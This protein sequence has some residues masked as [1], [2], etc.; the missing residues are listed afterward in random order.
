MRK[1]CLTIMVLFLVFSGIVFSAST[2]SATIIT[3][4]LGYEFSGA[5]EP[6]GS[7]LPWLVA[8]FDDNNTTGSVTLT[9]SAPG[10]VEV[11]Q[12]K[13]WYFN[14]DTSLLTSPL[15]YSHSSGP[16]AS[17]VDIS[18]NAYRA[19]GVGGD[20]DILFGFGGKSFLATSTATSP[21]TANT[22]SVYEFTATGLIA[23]NFNLSS[24]DPTDT[25]LSY[26][27]AAHIQSIDSITDGEDEGSGWIT[28]GGGG[29]GGGQNV[30]P[31]P[32][33]IFLLGGGLLMMAAGWR[34]KRKK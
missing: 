8:E 27:S 13:E 7:L 15:L 25:L 22:S 11:E 26:I 18:D 14:I 33:T 23:N 24:Y 10:L 17:S 29:G 28:D 31:A 1:N 3:I 30:I 5:D 9:M 6:E 16:L 20:F 21:P 2:G 4:E 34:R 12:I 19:D 32:S